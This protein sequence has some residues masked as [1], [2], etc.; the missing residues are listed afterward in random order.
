MGKTCGNWRTDVGVPKCRGYL[1]LEE[2][3]FDSLHSLRMK[4]GHAQTRRMRNLAEMR[5][6]DLV[7]EG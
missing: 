1:K 3:S 5:L 6:A 7:L 4:P 2:G